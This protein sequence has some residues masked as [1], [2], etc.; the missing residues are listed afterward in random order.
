MARHN[1][2]VR[3]HRIYMGFFFRGSWYCLLVES[4]LK[5]AL[6]RTFTFATAAKVVELV[7]RA[8]GFADLACRQATQ[9]KRILDR[10]DN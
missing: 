7:E 10:G 8:A 4:D 5:T 1:A 9:V 6:P 3:T 2:R